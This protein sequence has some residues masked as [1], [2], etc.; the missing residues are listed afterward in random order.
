[1]LGKSDRFARSDFGTRGR[2]APRECSIEDDNYPHRSLPLVRGILGDFHRCTP[3]QANRNSTSDCWTR[4]IFGPL[5]MVGL[6]C[7]PKQTHGPRCLRRRLQ[8]NIPR[9]G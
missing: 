8:S 9:P 3:L 4:G 1:M 7:L 6:G 5:D 2:E